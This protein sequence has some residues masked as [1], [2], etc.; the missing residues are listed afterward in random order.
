MTVTTTLA[1]AGNWGDY[2]PE[3][4]IAWRTGCGDCLV[5]HKNDR[6]RVTRMKPWRHYGVGKVK[7][8]QSRL[9]TRLRASLRILL[10]FPFFW[11]QSAP[12]PS[13]ACTVLTDPLIYESLLA[14]YPASPEQSLSRLMIPPSHTSPSPLQL[15]NL[16]SCQRLCFAVSAQPAVHNCSIANPQKSK[17]SEVLTDQF[18]RIA[19]YFLL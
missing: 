16:H 13:K 8:S 14:L 1:K 12:F 5:W 17:S 15:T 7:E 19:A 18:I 10:E 9:S 3:C 4:R 6:Q 2:R 11:N